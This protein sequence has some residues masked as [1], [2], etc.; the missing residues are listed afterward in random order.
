[1]IQ[2]PALTAPC[3]LSETGGAEPNDKTQED[4]QE[5]GQCC[6][7]KCSDDQ[8]NNM[9]PLGRWKGTQPPL[10][11]SIWWFR[12]YLCLEEGCQVRTWPTVHIISIGVV[13]VVHSIHLYQWIIISI[14][15]GITFANRLYRY[16]RISKFRTL[17]VL[18]PCLP[19]VVVQIIT[20]CCS[21]FS[22]AWHVRDRDIDW[23]CRQLFQV[24]VPVVVIHLLNRELRV[25]LAG[26]DR[27]TETDRNALGTCW[28]AICH[29]LRKLT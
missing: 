11:C 26:D 8:S 20:V 29:E 3:H 15:V 19:V 27:E 14:V 10:H 24:V 25:V 28:S 1:M 18:C 2:S 6:Y 17:L 16:V 5:Q 13:L 4:Q 7:W 9:V 21:W 22:P 23:L 12:V